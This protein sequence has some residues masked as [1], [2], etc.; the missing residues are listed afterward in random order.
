MDIPSVL[1]KETEQEGNQ[2]NSL[3]IL[4]G[5]HDEKEDRPRE[6]ILC[7]HEPEAD[8]KPQKWQK[9]IC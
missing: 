8:A 4:E 1:L 2:G 7:Y 6:K 5:A 9:M 3:E